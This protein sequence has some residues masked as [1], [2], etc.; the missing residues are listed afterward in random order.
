MASE[1]SQASK[2]PREA[3]GDVEARRWAD[4][5]DDLRTSLRATAVGVGLDLGASADFDARYELLAPIGSGA[6]SVV[7]VQSRNRRKRGE[8]RVSLDANQSVT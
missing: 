1:A 3:F 2:R 4:G 5:S 8:P 6:F 7:R